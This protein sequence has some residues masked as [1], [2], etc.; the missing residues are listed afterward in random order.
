MA[1]ERKPDFANNPIFQEILREGLTIQ[2]RFKAEPV[3]A[4]TGQG[5][6]KSFGV[7]EIEEAKKRSGEGT[8]RAGGPGLPGILRFPGLTSRLPSA[9]GMLQWRG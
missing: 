5:Y 9:A 2:D 3:E 4:R 7:S 8:R 6:L 1:E